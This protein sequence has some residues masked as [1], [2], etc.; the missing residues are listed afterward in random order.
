MGGEVASSP[1]R[2]PRELAPLQ[3]SPGAG[4]PGSP[5]KEVEAGSEY[6]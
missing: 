2:S 6:Y 1:A 4:S 3:G 5:A